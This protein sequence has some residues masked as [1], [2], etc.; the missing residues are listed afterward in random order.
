MVKKPIIRQYWQFIKNCWQS[1]LKFKLSC[2][3]LVCIMLAYFLLPNLSYARSDGYPKL[4][5]YFLKSPISSAE[6]EELAKWDVVILGMQIQDTNPE[7]FA[8][9]RALNPHIK[10]IAYLSAMEFP[11]TRLSDLESSSGPWHK[12]QSEIS[13]KWYLKDGSGRVHSIWPGNYS[14]NITEYCPEYNGQKFNEW[15]PNFVKKELMSS[16]K[17]DGVFYDNV[18]T[19]VSWKNEG[20]IDINN[21]YQ[22]D[23][24]SWADEAWREGMLTLLKNTRELLGKNKI[25]LVNSSSYGNDYINGRLYESWPDPWM[26]GWSGA[27]ED[28]KD[29]EKNIF[30]YPQI[31]VLNP[32][33]DNT[34]NRWDYDKVRFGLTSTLQGNGY[35]AFDY[36]TQDH[37]QLWYYDEYGVNLGYPN[38]ESKNIL[39]DVW[40]RNFTKGVVLVNSGN[41][42]QSVDLGPGIYEKIRGTQDPIT[43]NGELVKK[44]TLAPQD[45]IV[46]LKKLEVEVDSE[47]ILR[48][49]VFVNG[50]YVRVFDKKGQIKRSGFYAYDSRFAGGVRIVISDLDNDGNDETLVAEGSQIRIYNTDNLLISEFYPYG[51]N[52]HSEINLAVGNVM[53]GEEKEIVTGRGY[54][55]QPEVKIFNLKGEILHNGWMAYA[56]NFYGGVNLALGDLNGNGYKEIV[57]GA[58]FSGGPHVRIFDATGYLFDPGF[59]PFDPLFRGGIN[60]ACADLNGDNKDEIITGA[61]PTGGPHIQIYDKIGHL[62]DPGFFA[63]DEAK[64][65]GVRVGV[66]DVDGDGEIE[67]LGME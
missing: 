56:S 64:R 37:S 6:V 9:L 39:G 21:D 47:I 14:F 65:N 44:I 58:G 51:K 17:W 33:T 10:I 49:V 53:G 46:L 50:S 18:L 59:F 24:A 63:F 2:F 62:V 4:A 48:D 25:I 54:G 35:F 15:L 29:L 43:N 26:G 31:I 36:G 45:G 32:N 16:G 55:E 7:I 41:F 8:R 27:M 30:N 19:G 66:G 12:M 5:N 52:S 13:F 60:V 22:I 11:I 20:K 61:G 57:A 67:I 28:Y 1:K 3:A 38:S 42:S 23:E 34:G 40:R